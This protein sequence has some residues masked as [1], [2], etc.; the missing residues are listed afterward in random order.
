MEAVTVRT[1]S[2]EATG[3]D[4]GGIGITCCGVTGAA[5]GIAD[6]ALVSSGVEE[7]DFLGSTMIGGVDR[8]SSA[9]RICAAV[10]ER[11]VT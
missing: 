9:L 6:A 3:G 5:V 11:P 10:I 7:P 2:L 4:A 1:A 8:L